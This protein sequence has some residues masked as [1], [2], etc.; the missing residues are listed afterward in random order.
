[1]SKYMYDRN[2]DGIF[3]H[4]L[5]KTWEKTM[6]AAR[7]IAAIQSKNQKDV[8]VSASFKTKQVVAMGLENF[9]ALL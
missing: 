9:Q 3:Y 8:L 6:V 1:M 7:I 5:A 2:R 4:D